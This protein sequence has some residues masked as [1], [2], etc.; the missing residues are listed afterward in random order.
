MK[1]FWMPLLLCFGLIGCGSSSKDVTDQEKRQDYLDE[2]IGLYSGAFSKD[3]RANLIR[4]AIT[5]AGAFLIITDDMENSTLSKA[6]IHASESL[7]NFTEGT[8][9]AE[10]IAFVCEFEDQSIELSANE[11]DEL[12]LV[13]GEYQVGQ[14]NEIAVIQL[15]DDGTFSTHVNNCENTG[16]FQWV[17]GFWLIT[18]MDCENNNVIGLGFGSVGQPQPN[19]IEVL[20]ED[21]GLS[22]QWVQL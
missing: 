5:A 17:D 15:A 16:D 21:Q 6:S 20:M 13:S 12:T 19:S 11:Q 7:L 22:G 10:Q 9:H 4:L 14:N 8:C 3:Q 18:Q 1:Y 2:H